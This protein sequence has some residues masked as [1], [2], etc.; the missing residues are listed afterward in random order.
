M[1]GYAR[2]F[3]NLGLALHDSGNYAEALAHLRKAV[4]LEPQI[5]ECHYNLANTLA[6]LGRFDEMAAEYR[7]TLEIDPDYVEAHNNF[8]A[9]FYGRGQFDEAIAEFQAALNIK[10]DYTDARDNLGIAQ[11][12]REEIQKTLIRRREALRQ[13]PDDPAL[14]N[15]TAWM[16]ATNPNASIRNGA[17][18]VELAGR[19]VRLSGGRE[20]A[21]L[22]TLAAAYAEAGRFSEAQDTARKALD[23]AARQD[24]HPLAESLKGKI[25]LYEAGTPF[26]EMSQP[27]AAGSTPP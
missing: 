4:E 22:G 2:A 6:K 26:R 16:L 27:A 21:V 14:L 18:A 7:R 10:P 15:D 19:A 24:N 23:L 11:S 8:G 25:L 20:P 13:R 9:A 17:E 5:A 3:N 12:R 1:P